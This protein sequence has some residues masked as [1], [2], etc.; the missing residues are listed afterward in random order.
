MTRWLPV[1]GRLA[2][3]A[4]L[5][6]LVLPV[7]ALLVGGA[8][9]D[10]ATA[11]RDPAVAPAVWLTLRTSLTA[12]ALIVVSGTPLAW[13]LATSR[14]S[15]PQ[16]VGALVDLPVVVPPA[17]L[18]V[19]LLLA[20]GPQAPL[21]AALAS[22]GLALPFTEPAVVVA[23][24]VV[25]APFY[26]QAA[27]SA[28][29]RVDPDLL[30]VAHTLGAS[31]PEAFLRVA[32]PLAAPGL[33]AGASLAWARA[34]GEFGATLLFAGNLPGVTQTLPLAVLSAME[35]RLEVALAL[36]LV[37]LGL[38]FVALL[39]VRAVPGRGAP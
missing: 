36:S 28:F 31:P 21:G 17:V 10:L 15:L 1:A 23:Q 22:V 3:G 7:G 25:A 37:L 30:I 9:G 2:A 6:L 14:G 38:G 12:L 18:G 39:G 16:V 35:G 20:L 26:I 8:A 32:L 24:V 19:G 33:V 5:L 34:V 27:A 4:L 29:R 11:A 13:W